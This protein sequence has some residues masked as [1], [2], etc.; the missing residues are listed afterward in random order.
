MNDGAKELIKELEPLTVLDARSVGQRLDLPDDPLPTFEVVAAELMEYFTANPVAD[1]V[2]LSVGGHPA[3]VVSRESLRAYTGGM[4][5]AGG[6]AGAGEAI[7]LPGL[8]TRYRLLEFTC[9]KCPSQ[10]RVHYEER[11][12]P[13]CGHGQMVPR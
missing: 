13:A 1:E 6:T 12:I 11:D 10:Y 9:P 7:Q 3:G 8:S 5:G 4:A 2:N